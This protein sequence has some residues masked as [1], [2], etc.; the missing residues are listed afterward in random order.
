M[1]R[2]NEYLT[3][4]GVMAAYTAALLVYS[5][6][7]AFTG[8]E[9]F[10]LLAAQL[11]R[12][13]MRPYLDFFFPQTPWNAWWNAAWMSIFGE[14]WRVAHA[15]AALMTSAAVFL[16]ADYWFRRSDVDQWRLAGSV[17]AGLLTGLCGVV[18]AYGPVAQAY[19]L[20][21]LLTVAAYRC[22]LLA[23]ER[24]GWLLSAATG[25]LVSTAAGCSLL[26][27]PETIILFLWIV[28]RT[29]SWRKAAAFAAAAVVPWV[30][31]FKMAAASPRVVWFNLV[32][33]HT[34]FRHLYWPDTTEH[35]IDVLTGWINNGQALTLL[36][37]AISGLF[38]VKYR[39][40]RRRDD[41]YLCAGLAAALATEISTA[42]PTFE[43]YYLLAVPFV[44]I[45]A[46]A[47]LYAIGS[48]VFGAERPWWPVIV[49]LAISAL[50][51]AK[52]IYERRNLYTWGD[53]ESIAK[54]IVAV[55]PPG[56]SL[57]ADDHV[58][59]VLHRKPPPGL[60]FAYSHK[61][62]LPPAKRKSLHILTEDEVNR[63]ISSGIYST[64]YIC[65][66]DE[67]YEKLGLPKLYKH[68]EDIEDCALFSQRAR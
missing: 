30:P 47:G 41:F 57:Y 7:W 36:V 25:L 32:Q 35:D 58:Y 9:G 48:R 16:T 43:R 68:R 60:E 15:V 24:G 1:G 18:A 34:Q 61:L 64:V 62:D 59:F 13:G 22:C 40:T 6:T 4:C 55:T 8:D 39:G 50:G 14:S 17:T 66:D 49:V 37:L 33:Y 52:T 26:T 19:A 10:H 5:Q 56:G 38:F 42:H 21:L 54:K 67:T 12:S 45:P 29:H 11:I 28:F 20:C 53:Y 3:L 63:Q 44:A 46:V 23:V 2:R 27:A 31:V 65:E 51:C